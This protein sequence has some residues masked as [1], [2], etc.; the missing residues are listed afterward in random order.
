MDEKL[1]VIIS[2]EV[3]KL[4]QG[5]EKAKQ[6]VKGLQGKFQEASKTIKEDLAKA[7][8][9]ATNLA[10][11]IGAGFTAIGASLVAAAA[12]TEEYRNQQAQLKTA[13]EAA[14]ASA[15][16]ATTT[17]NG[18][19][20]VLG[21]G[22]Q[23]QEA[24]QHLAKLTT[25]EKALNEWNTIL[26][27]TFA[28]YGA[29]LPLEGLTEAVNHSSKLGS[30]QS[31]LADALEWSGISVDTFNEQ[32]AAC[33]GE[34]ERE[35]LIRETLLGLYGEAAATYEKN[36][37]Q[38]LAQRDA[39][40]KLQERLAKVG[41]ALAPVITAFT[42]LAAN[43][44]AK[45]EPYI[46]SLA[47]KYMPK[48]EEILKKVGDAIGS[49]IKW[50]TD[51]W[52][53]ISTIADVVLAIVA[54]FTAYNAVMKLVNAANLLFAANPIVLAIG[55]IIAIIVLCVKHWDDIKT[56][57]VNAW[58]GIK[59]VWGV[60]A[61]WFSGIVDGIKNAFTNI[62]SWFKEKFTQARDNVNKAFDNIGSW[63]SDKFT[64]AK[65]GVEKAWSSTKQFFTNSNKSIQDAF[66]KVDS[67][68]SSKFG[69]AWDGVKQAF[70]PFVG[71]F[72]QCWETVKGIFSVVK[73]V[74]TGNF[75]GAWEG[76][77]GIFSGWANFFTGLW[78]TI[79][80]IFSKVG[81]AIG[82]GIK[83]AVSSAVNKVLSTAAKII[84]GFISGINFAIDIINAIP[85]VNIK[86]LSSLN[87]PQMAQG[88]VV[89]SATLA[90]I[91]ERGK[92]AVMPLENNLEWLDKLA[93]M[94][95]Q[96]MGGNQPIVLNVDGKR[97]GEIAVDS[98][99]GITRQRG[100]IPLVIS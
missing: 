66:S 89:D 20:R 5:V 78:N 99:N 74:L 13:F 16:Q 25:E 27:G 8:E 17:Y 24:A 90:V 32:L 43:A 39:Q 10:T 28:T 6:A 44:L 96:R 87:V 41:E 53:L 21:D 60:V 45:V 36:N 59:A 51:N 97:F 52:A 2:A 3:S 38:V 42:N 88:G 40:A 63:F 22:G 80:N 29:S 69:S 79:K 57:A 72:R 35:K 18:L 34:A 84:N 7:G 12:S 93:G 86:R 61:D 31:S 47:E 33:N 58:D 85:G 48:L 9:G 73:D 76:I 49:V 98:I 68:M 14:G 26:Q 37:A 30:V 54:A 67:Y 81:T 4:Q 91:G 71:Y 56:A 100:S 19:Y 83:G 77:K 92:E 50:I 95:N 55:A 1:K 11:K 65:Q 70:A 46:T 94:L 75:S 62:G 23:A 82:D 15:E 64:K